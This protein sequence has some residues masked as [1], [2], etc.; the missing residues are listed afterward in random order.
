MLGP[1]LPTFVPVIASYLH[2][3]RSLQHQ[4]E[5]SN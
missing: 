4:K 5:E 3:S 1:F 2:T